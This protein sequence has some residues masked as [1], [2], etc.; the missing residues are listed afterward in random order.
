MILKYLKYYAVTVD[1]NEARSGSG[2]GCITSC[3]VEL[4]ASRLNVT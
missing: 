1:L 2:A 3:L 4:F